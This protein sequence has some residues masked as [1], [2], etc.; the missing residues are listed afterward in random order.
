VSCKS[1]QASRSKT[2]KIRRTKRGIKKRRGC[3]KKRSEEDIV[4]LA[5]VLPTALVVLGAQMTIAAPGH[6]NIAG[7]MNTLDPETP[8]TGGLVPGPLIE[9]TPAVTLCPPAY[10]PH[11]IDRPTSRVAQSHLVAG[12]G[13]G[14]VAEALL[15]MMTIGEVLARTILTRNGPAAGAQDAAL[16][17]MNHT[18]SGRVL[19]V[20]PL[21]L[22]LLRAINLQRTT[23]QPGLLRCSLMPPL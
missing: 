15:A 23:G 9:Q 8:T 12:T 2:K 19:S 17:T 1:V 11:M 13:I 22:V 16:N 3:A 4:T 18:P 10:L 20:L 21:P 6:Q 14:G 7:D 5:L